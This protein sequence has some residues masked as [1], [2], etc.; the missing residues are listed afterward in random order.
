LQVQYAE[1]YK[2]HIDV[3]RAAI[4]KRHERGEQERA[5]LQERIKERRA[6][7]EKHYKTFRHYQEIAPLV[8]NELERAAEQHFSD[9]AEARGYIERII[10][11]LSV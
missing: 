9:E 4:Q 8:V 3:W 5:L 11:R 2:R 1:I 7:Q 10:K 6:L